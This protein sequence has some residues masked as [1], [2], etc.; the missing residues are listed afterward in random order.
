MKQNIPPFTQRAEVP[1]RFW[2]RGGVWDRETRKWVTLIDGER[3]TSDTMRG[4]HS[5]M[6]AARMQGKRVTRP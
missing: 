4:I 6:A 2:P 1:E 3:H 5:I